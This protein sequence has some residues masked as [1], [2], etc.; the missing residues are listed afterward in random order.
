MRTSKL[1]NVT[2][3]KVLLTINYLNEL[4]YIPSASGVLKILTGVID[5]ETEM[6]SLCP[7]FQVLVSYNPKRL[8]RDINSLVTN[9]YLRRFHKGEFKDY[10]FEITDMGKATLIHY[11][12]HHKVNLKKHKPK[13]KPTIIKK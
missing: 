8:T 5:E 9:G 7:T 10:Y 6:F 4:G 12:S 13:K 3:Y 1:I 2:D 11:Q